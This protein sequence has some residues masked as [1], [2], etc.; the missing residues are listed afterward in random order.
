MGTMTDDAYVYQVPVMTEGVGFEEVRR[1]H[2]QHFIG[3]RPEDTKITPVSRPVAE[4]QVVDEIPL[5]FTHDI[6]MDQ[7]AGGSPH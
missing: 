2:G 7:L 4:D 1:F 3:K 5:S 6:E